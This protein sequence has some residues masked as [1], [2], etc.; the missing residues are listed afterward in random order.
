MA[1]LFDFSTLYHTQ[2]Y[3][4]YAIALAST[5]PASPRAFSFVRPSFDDPQAI[6]AYTGWL[7]AH[8]ALPLPVDVRADDR[9]LTLVTCHGQDH[10]ERLI[11][12]LRAL[13]PVETPADVQHAF[14]QW[15]KVGL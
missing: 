6:P 9:L 7:Q 1:P 11:L 2:T 5:D 3:V 14:A 15:Q 13:R 10:N 12:A 8:S 4:P